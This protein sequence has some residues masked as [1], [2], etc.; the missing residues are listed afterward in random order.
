MALLRQHIK[1]LAH[2]L[3]A[4]LC[5]PERGGDYRACA[6]RGSALCP[7]PPVFSVEKLF[8]SHVCTLARTLFAI[9]AGVYSLRTGT[10]FPAFYSVLVLILKNFNSD[11][12][13]SWCACKWLHLFCGMKVSE[14]GMQIRENSLTLAMK[15]GISCEL[16]I[17]LWFK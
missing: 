10:H 16:H 14:C 4:S 3:P 2:H 12:A 6:G 15:A 9:S 5:A 13:I 11:F 7:E 17:S 1:A 8:D